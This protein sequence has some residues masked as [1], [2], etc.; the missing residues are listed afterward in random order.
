MSGVKPGGD[1]L[2]ES[3]SRDYG[4]KAGSPRSFGLIV[5]GALLL[6]GA[7]P[8]IAGRAPWI[9]PGA[10]GIALM[11]LALLAPAVLQPLNLAWTVLGRV[12][13][14]IFDPIFLG[15]LFFCVL[16]PVGWLMRAAGKDPL[17][18]KRDPQAPSYWIERSPPG[19]APETM[20]DQF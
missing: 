4:M 16:T 18:L 5:G 8:L 20:K 9:W 12:M 15:F 3:F 13:Q 2:H 19:P 11:A 6:I 14:R 17:H 7:Y 1:S 10:A